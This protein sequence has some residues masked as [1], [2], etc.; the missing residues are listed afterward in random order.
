[1][2]GAFLFQY[3][4]TRY[5][6]I[7]LKTVI[8]VVGYLVVNLVKIIMSVLVVRVYAITFVL[9]VQAGA[10]PDLPGGKVLSLEEVERLQQTQAVPN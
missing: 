3:I 5:M 4:F 6:E 9:Q 2:P 10:L 8:L 1:M 7:L